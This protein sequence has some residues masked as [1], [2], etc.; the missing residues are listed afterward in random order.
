MVRLRRRAKREVGPTLGDSCIECSVL[1]RYPLTRAASFV[2]AFA[3]VA[4]LSTREMSHA[5]LRRG[6]AFAHTVTSVTTIR[7]D[8]RWSKES[9]VS[10]SGTVVVAP[11]ATLTIDPGTRIEAAPGASLVVSRDARILASGTVLEPIVFTC[12][13]A[14]SSA[15]CWR[16]LVVQ[17][18][19]PINF[20]TATSPAARGNGA[21]G[22]LETVDLVV[23]GTPFGGCD[24]ADD[25]GVI[26]FV[27]VE[28][29][30]RGVQLEGVGSGTVIDRLQVNR[31]RA[32]GLTVTGGVAR[33][34]RLFLTANGGAGLLWTGGWVG[35]G[36]FIIVYPDP[37]GFAAGV[38]GQNR[39]EGPSDDVIPRSAPTL[40]NVTI[41]G[42]SDPTN[43]SHASA[44][45]LVLERGTSML[46]RNSIIVAPQIAL[47]L[48]DPATCSALQAGALSN[49]ITAG[50]VRLDDPDSDASGCGEASA[51]QDAAHFTSVLPDATRLLAGM[52]GDLVTP[53]LRLLP[54]T[55]AATAPI[56]PLPPESSFFEAAAHLGAVPVTNASRSTVPW[57]T[58]WTS[59]APRGVDADADGFTPASGDCN[60]SAPG[61]N[62]LAQDLPDSVRVDSNCD[63]IDG[64]V[65]QAIFVAPSGSDS[66]ACGGIDTPCATIPTG[67]ARAAMSGRR[68]VYVAGGT[69]TGAELAL[70]NGVHLFGGYA[71]TFLVRDPTLNPVILHRSPT[72]GVQGVTVRASALTAPTIVGDVEIVGPAMTTSG[73]TSYA[74]VAENIPAGLLRLERVRLTAGAGAAGVAGLSAPVSPATT[75]EMNGGPGAAGLAST[76]P[77]DA[78]TRGAGGLPGGNVAVGESSLGGV[79][80]AGGTADALCISFGGPP[81]CLDCVARDGSVGG[82]AFVSSAMFGGGGSG[83]TGGTMC[84]PATPG[85]A[86]ANGIDGAPGLGGFGGVVTS[87][88]W[89]TSKGG[90]GDPGGD[91][92]GGGGGGG[93]GGCDTGNSYGAGGGGGGAGGAGGQ[94]GR[95]G[96]GGGA[97]IAMA[98]D[99]A[100]PEL[101][102]VI[103]RLGTAGAGG[104][105]G[106]GAAGQAGGMGGA[107]GSAAPNGSAGAA[108]GS[109]GRGGNSAG[110]GGGAGG[111]AVGILRTTSA[112]TSTL[113]RVSFETG[114]ASAGSGGSGGTSPGAAAGG[115]GVAGR[116]ET[117]WTCVSQGNCMP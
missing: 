92:G 16:G 109:G 78:F 60:D 79:G 51:L 80:G 10:L 5:V 39:A 71:S 48:D 101:V 112:S 9:G 77:C 32:N 96:S 85:V 107:G 12:T 61:I 87:W 37:R 116:V 110:G 2:P 18:Y 8:T 53:D 36:Q 70:A 99:N 47:D 68:D 63:G 1:A 45:S 22:C 11:G 82:A 117:Q 52:S 75:L 111:P 114:A 115:A 57:F 64:D 55:A 23:G 7:T 17:G 56:A 95:G 90:D 84:G 65:D 29:A 93:A 41:I 30:E 89:V 31:S 83:G 103:V 88:Q 34:K 100:S 97:S 73:G 13:A 19:A 98:L 44:R 40:F 81:S 25:S 69:Y 106:N 104:S 24:G 113:L 94:R 15:G 27:R 58:A 66:P 105:G 86:G 50:A 54:A 28:Y 38:V 21:L 6:A 14:T 67:L 33:L 35:S 91:G 102:D 74:F 3:V 46:L 76:A 20:G 4:I 108:G 49:V 72:T 42:A 59:P 62:P 43:R 26:R